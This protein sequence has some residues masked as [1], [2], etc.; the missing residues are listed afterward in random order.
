YPLHQTTAPDAGRD[1]TPSV[2]PSAS[3][4]TPDRAPE[5]GSR[6]GDDGAAR[7]DGRL[8][9]LA[10]AVAAGS[11]V[12]FLVL[13][14]DSRRRRPPAPARSA[15]PSSP[16]RPLRPVERA[17]PD[18]GRRLPAGAPGAPAGAG[19]GAGAKRPADTSGP[20]RPLPPE[21]ALEWM[22]EIEWRQTVGNPRFHVIAR[23]GG[24]REATIAMSPPIAWPPRDGASLDALAEAVRDLDTQLVAGGWV[25]SEPGSAWYAKRFTWSPA[26]GRE[27]S[28]A[29]TPGAARGRARAA[30][31]R[32]P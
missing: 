31:A 12:G 11:G 21:P 17:R 23:S 20:P 1:P 27:R 8:L 7:G 32:R 9:R 25:P 14:V 2:S 3:P 24:K 10:L 4:A 19:A 28:P 15:R 6:P 26:S 16:A 22:A 18:P 13:L 30:P 5:G 29:S